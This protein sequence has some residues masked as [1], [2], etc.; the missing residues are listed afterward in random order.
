MYNTRNLYT[1]WMFL[2]NFQLKKSDNRGQN[3]STNDQY[4]VK[5]AISYY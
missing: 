4:R 5:R 1:F 2:V 3:D